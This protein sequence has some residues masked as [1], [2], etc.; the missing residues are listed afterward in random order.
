MAGNA[1][2]GATI[3]VAG[4]TGVGKTR[5]GIE[6]A[7]RLGGEII[8]ADSRQIYRGLDIGTAKATAAERQQVRHHLVDV[9]EPDEV[10]SAG[11][12]GR[13]ARAL[14]RELCDRGAVPVVVGG[15]GLYLAAFLDGFSVPAPSTDDGLRRRLHERL[16]Q[17]GAESLYE[18]LGRLDP[19][20]QA[21]LQP[22][23]RHRLVRALERLYGPEPD[24]SAQWSP[25]PAMPTMV[26][27][28]APREILYRQLDDRVVHMIEGGWREE[29]EGLVSAGWAASV[30][31]LES[32]GYREM[33]D[34]VK[35]ELELARAMPAI[36]QHTRRYAKRQLTWF[37]GD[38]R[39]RWLD[40][41]RL[42]PAGAA[43][44]I[45]AQWRRIQAG[46]GA[47][48]RVDTAG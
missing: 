28:H 25:L 36:Q 21:A 30:P 45:A 31:G 40:V 41:E 27:L 48:A 12:F 1:Y 20:T 10:Y 26:C 4:P 47:V 11:R 17:R 13:E 43:A 33:I 9:A 5:V 35:G 7:G 14:A 42:G 2:S 15:S 3:V 34:V 38:R 19:R 44:R 22:G 39:Y 6:V 24:L 37:R 8:S 32:L 23:D 29:V 46:A 16:D 18:E